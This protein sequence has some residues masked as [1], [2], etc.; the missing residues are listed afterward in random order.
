MSSGSLLRSRRVV[1]NN[2]GIDS[3]D[4]KRDQLIRKINVFANC[5]GYTDKL[6]QLIGTFTDWH[7]LLLQSEDEGFQKFASNQAENL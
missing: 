1:R 3:L 7:H 2:F 5:Q 6:R 4:W